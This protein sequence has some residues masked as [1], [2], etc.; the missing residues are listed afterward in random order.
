MKQ[1]TQIIIVVCALSGT[2]ACRKKPVVPE[3]PV[4]GSVTVD[5]DANL[6]IVRNKETV[7]GNMICDA[8]MNDMVNKGKTVDFVMV[9]GGNIRFSASKRP[10]GIYPAGAI[11]AGE[12]DEMLPFGDASVI[13]KVNGKQLKEI[14]ERSCAQLPLS[15][16]PFMQLS[17][18]IKVKI[19]PT[20][21]PQL[22]SVDEN[23][24]T[25]AGNRVVSVTINDAPLD[26]LAEYKVVLPSY[27]AE[28]ND[29]YV[30]LKNI[31]AGKKE[32]LG[33][34]QA[35]AVKEYITVFS[36]L[37]PVLDGRVSFQ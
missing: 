18:Q 24:I 9:N 26:S 3:S 36:P 22:L 34:N 31:S 23:S 21:S 37:T 28:G 20:K 11:T 15:M 8:V 14:L 35:N 4:L 19:D 33:E 12:V 10:N 16:G 2:I 25:S 30:T 5:L 13:V 32:N 29:G 27:I 1:I 17:K 7:I 6:N